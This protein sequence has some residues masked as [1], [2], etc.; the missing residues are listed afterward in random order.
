MNSGSI[1]SGIATYTLH[2]VE[3]VVRVGAT[4]VHS[5]FRG[6]SRMHGNLTPTVFRP[7]IGGG[8]MEFWAGERFRQRARQFSSRVPA[9]DDHVGW[10]LMMQHYGTP[11]RLL[12]WT[13]SVLVALYFAVGNSPDDD[14]EIWCMRPDA[15]NI[16]SNWQLS[17]PSS[18]P[19]RYLAAEVFEDKADLESLRSHLNLESRPTKPFAFFPPMEFPRM[20][21][22]LGRFTIHPATDLRIETLLTRPEDIVRYRIPAGSKPGFCRTL[23][24]LGVTEESLFQSLEALS[25]TIIDEIGERTYTPPAPPK[26]D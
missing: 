23:T 4:L 25:R 12:D 11:T 10:L 7:P 3:D 2:T 19:I 20:A 17:G 21:S 8:A 14:G 18:P 15:L 24:A 6:H 22:Q 26:F 1:Q 16:C 9:W 5:W 13:D